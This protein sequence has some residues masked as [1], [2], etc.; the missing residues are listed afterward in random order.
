MTVARLASVVNKLLL[1]TF[2][3]NR[4]YLIDDKTALADVAEFAFVPQEFGLCVQK[5]LARLE[6][7]AVEFLVAVESING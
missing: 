6:F 3:L 2:V 4:K 1:V 5:T 7:T